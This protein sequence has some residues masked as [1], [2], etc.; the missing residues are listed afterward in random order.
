MTTYRAGAA[1]K[2]K[3]INNVITNWIIIT[4][5]KCIGQ[6]RKSTTDNNL[7]LE[8]PTTTEPKQPWCMAANATRGQMVYNIS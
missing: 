1:E 7:K 6:G 3:K 8:T 2:D 4:E 5:V